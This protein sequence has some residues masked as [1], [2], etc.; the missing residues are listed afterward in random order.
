MYVV[1]ESGGGRRGFGKE[2]VAKATERKIARQQNVFDL[3]CKSTHH[4]IDIAT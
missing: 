2:L 1:E 4:D 3:N